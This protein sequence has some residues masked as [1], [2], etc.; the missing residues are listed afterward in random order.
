MAEK[1]IKIRE[2]FDDISERYDFLNHLLSM[3]FDRSWRKHLVKLLGKKNP[4]TILEVATGTGDLAIALAKIEP[5]TIVGIDIAGKMV[6]IARTKV[7]ERGL[8]SLISLK[9]GDAE[10]IPF[11]DATFDAV[12][13]AF[14]VRNFEDLVLGLTEMKRILRPGGSMMILEFSHPASFPFKQLYG[15]YSALCIPLIGRLV[16]R[17]YQAYRYLP[18][19]IRFFPSGR[20][21]LD[22]LDKIGMRN[23]QQV[24]LTLGVA[25]VYIAEK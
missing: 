24:I 14:G 2:M 18:D 23:S 16:S 4:R 15:I 10:K 8:E 6:E 22:I 12:T 9:Q 7:L 3:N 19:S 25:S 17:N 21:F 11:S 1:K 13:V 5:E 20:H